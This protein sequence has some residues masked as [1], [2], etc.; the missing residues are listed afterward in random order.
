[1]S[2]I[3]VAVLDIKPGEDDTIYEAVEGLEA[4]GDVTPLLVGRVFEEY[5][6]LILLHTDSMDSLDDYL[7]KHVRK[8]AATQELVVVPIYE[9]ATLPS[10]D[11]LVEID[12]TD[13]V[14][15][16][17][18]VSFSS[19]EEYLMLMA[20]IDVAPQMDRAVHEA[21]MKLSKDD[22]IIPLMT[23][24]TFHSKEFDM[25]LF[26]LSNDLN[27]AWEF[28]KLIRSIDGVWDTQF[29][30]LAHFE[31]LVPLRRFRELLTTIN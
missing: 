15:D 12:E 6:I 16:E 24:H 29:N 5:D 25:V 4:A 26:F 19:D 22:D 18:A 2:V 9:F 7:I 14:S 31:P 8:Y 17:T 11:S 10:F 30:I 13:P 27:A 21:V 23:G 3:Y 20:K 1:M 28:G